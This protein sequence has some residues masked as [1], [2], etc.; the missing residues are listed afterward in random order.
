[1][2]FLRF[3]IIMCN[4]LAIEAI[5]PYI[6]K[7]KKIKLEINRSLNTQQKTIPETKFFIFLIF[8]V[9]FVLTIVARYKKRNN[10]R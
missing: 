3:F 1:M 5:L 8:V 7:Y 9:F 2:N 6:G 4:I 10:N